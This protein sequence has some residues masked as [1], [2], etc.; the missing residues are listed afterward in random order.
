MCFLRPPKPKKN[1]NV[2]AKYRAQASSSLKHAYSSHYY[3]YYYYGA[4]VGRSGARGAPPAG[5]SAAAAAGRELPAILPL[6][7]SE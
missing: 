7:S 5:G 6:G 2:M 4:A 1:R 3:Y